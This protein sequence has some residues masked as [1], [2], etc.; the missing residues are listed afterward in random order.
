MRDRFFWRPKMVDQYCCH[1]EA[2]LLLRCF[3]FTAFHAVLEM[4][5]NDATGGKNQLAKVLNCYLELWCCAPFWKKNHQIMSLYSWAVSHSQ[6]GRH[7]SWKDGATL[8]IRKSWPLEWI[9]KLIFLQMTFTSRRAAWLFSFAS[10]SQRLG[11]N[12]VLNAGE[13]RLVL[14]SGEAAPSD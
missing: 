11:Q 8:S 7:R 4:R 13:L 1:G 6:G 2:D 5:R 14:L 10:L 12:F 3:Y 9:M